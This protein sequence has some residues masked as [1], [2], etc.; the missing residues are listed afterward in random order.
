MSCWY[1]GHPTDSKEY[2]LMLEKEE[3]YKK[4]NDLN[5]HL[6]VDRME[7]IYGVEDVTPER[8]NESERHALTAYIEAVNRYNEVRERY[9][10]TF[11]EAKARGENTFVGE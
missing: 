5:P 1:V 11:E 10:R 8:F 3:A 4:M 7:Y 9:I 6:G 2:K